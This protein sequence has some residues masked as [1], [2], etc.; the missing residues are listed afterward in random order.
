MRSHGDAINPWVVDGGQGASPWPPHQHG[1][2]STNDDRHPPDL[3]KSK[4]GGYVGPEI[5]GT[6]ERHDEPP[7]VGVEEGGDASKP[8][9]GGAI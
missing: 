2:P 5:G 7:M 1:R 8:L 6:D 9:G 3:G 4:W